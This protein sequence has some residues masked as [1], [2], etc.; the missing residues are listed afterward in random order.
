MVPEKPLTA[1]AVRVTIC[2]VPPAFRLTLVGLNESEKSALAS[3]LE[4]LPQPLTKHTAIRTQIRIRSSFKDLLTFWPRYAEHW[5]Q[6]T[7]QSLRVVEDGVA[8]T[9]IQKCS[10]DA[11]N[12]PQVTHAPF[13]GSQDAVRTHSAI[14]CGSHCE[15]ISRWVAREPKISGMGF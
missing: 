11:R 2:A 4:P 14:R 1:A 13:G 3:G 15:H 7:L 9:G 5:T 12:I 6:P 8:S 10:F